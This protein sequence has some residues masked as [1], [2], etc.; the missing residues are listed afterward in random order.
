MR[1]I[2]S[3]LDSCHCG[4]V[5]GTRGP[6]RPPL[7]KVVGTRSAFALPRSL[8][9]GA[10]GRSVERETFAKR[11][12]ESFVWLPYRVS[13]SETLTGCWSVLLCV[14]LILTVSFLRIPLKDYV[15][16]RT[17]T[18]QAEH[19]FGASLRLPGVT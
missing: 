8:R 7:G 13:R 11:D 12:G 18:A 19:G 9:F 3:L 16:R 10:T 15:A 1:S 14:S 5:E 6:F 2:V 4:I 17:T